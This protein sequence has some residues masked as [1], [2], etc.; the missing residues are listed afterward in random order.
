MTHIPSRDEQG[1]I[2][3]DSVP[4]DVL[5][6]RVGPESAGSLTG[7]ATRASS[8]AGIQM[9]VT[10]SFA[11]LTTLLTGGILSQADYG[12]AGTALGIVVG[13][14]VLQP[15][16]FADVLMA[17]PGS[18][19]R[20]V[21]R[22]QRLAVGFGVLQAALI[23]GS[24]PVVMHLRPEDA[25][26]PALLAALAL[27]PL[28]D[29]MLV[30]PLAALRYRLDVVKAPTV[31]GLAGMLA[32][33]GSVCMALSGAAAISIILPQ[34]LAT[35][36][37]AVAYRHLSIRLPAAD[38]PSDQDRAFLVRSFLWGGL[39]AYVVSFL[40][41]SETLVM[42]W[43]AVPAE[44]I[45]VFTF[46]YLI[47]SQVTTVMAT[48]VAGSLHPLFSHM[49]GEGVRMSGAFL[50]V[51]RVL[52]CLVVPFSIAQ[53]AASP[54]LFPLIW[55]EKWLSAIPV[56][57]AVS[58]AQAASFALPTVSL[59][60]KAQ[61]R[62]KA[63]LLLNATYAGIAVALYSAICGLS[64][65][66]ASAASQFGIAEQS[67]IPT[68]IALGNALTLMVLGPIA[69]KIALPRETRGSTGCSGA[70]FL[71]FVVTLPIGAVTYLAV[72]EVSRGL[73]TDRL[74]LSTIVLIAFGVTF[75]FGSLVSA[76]MSESAWNDL[77]EMLRR[78]LVR[79]HLH[80][81]LR[82]VG[83]RARPRE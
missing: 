52:G 5:A 39:G 18:L 62:F 65:P 64:R 16:V 14:T 23:A 26:L 32:N 73:Q 25:Q 19:P 83:S 28:F 55:G 57:V 75:L 36:A 27:R 54:A 70:Y 6:D 37:R 40:Q 9:A 34:V 38:P 77:S 71:P 2:D 44:V 3:P 43:F 48:Q 12:A 31:D 80:R 49:Q 41:M 42:S 13:L 15:W 45:G 10:K 81:L 21:D 30:K 20:R 66:W 7:L 8:A 22:A 35:A 47:A 67:L 72:N 68:S 46:A 29:A 51:V 33:A 61:G 79:L 63:M 56:F 53:A 50:R 78:L 82:G 60:L 24:I 74:A 69:L 58:T 1:R 17:D 59:M 4:D 11:V 76:R